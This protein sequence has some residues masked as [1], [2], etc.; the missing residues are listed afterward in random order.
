ML[1][2]INSQT[3]IAEIIAQYSYDATG[4]NWNK[5]M[6][7]AQL[8]TG[9][10]ACL[11]K[12]DG[13]YYLYRSP[14]E[15]IELLS[16]PAAESPQVESSIVDET[17]EYR[18]DVIKSE[19]PNAIAL[20]KSKLEQLQAKQEMMKTVN[21]LAKKQDRLGLKQLGLSDAAVEELLN[22]PQSYMRPGY[23]SY[24]LSN[25]NQTI[26]QVKERIKELS[27]RENWSG[28]SYDTTAGIEV[29][30]D[31]DDN[32]IR[33]V[34]DRKPSKEICKLLKT[35]GFKYSPTNTAWQRMLNQQSRTTTRWVLEEIT[36]L[37]QEL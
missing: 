29:K 30:E 28:T 37:Q 2:I 1:T 7:Q 19:D 5:E 8:K 13:A 3:T 36:K 34:F 6:L 11:T 27:E 17:V 35:R 16:T 21:K 18:G 15:K 31:F 12:E 20:L 33:I 26:R 22:P 10:I 14:Q 4:T 25:N 23:Q 32:R 9:E 24:E